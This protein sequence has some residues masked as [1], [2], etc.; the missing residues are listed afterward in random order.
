MN[1]NLLLIVVAIFATDLTLQARYG[2]AGRGRGGAGRGAHGGYHGGG[3]GWGGV[4]AGVA[5]GA[6]VGTTVAVAATS[7]S[8]NNQQPD[9]VAQAQADQMRYDQQQYEQDQADKKRKRYS[10]DDYNNDDYGRYQD[11]SGNSRSRRIQQLQA[12]I[13]LL[14]SN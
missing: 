6:I 5:T 8:R 11:E 13:D 14:E 9:P 1:K 7:G 10:D 12:Q 3:Y 4:G 2:G